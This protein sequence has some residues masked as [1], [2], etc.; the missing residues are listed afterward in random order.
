MNEFISLCLIW[1]GIFVF[2]TS[3]IL[4]GGTRCPYCMSDYGFELKAKYGLPIMFIC[5]ISIAAGVS[6]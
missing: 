1:C 5:L 3:M 4:L 2:L 6:L